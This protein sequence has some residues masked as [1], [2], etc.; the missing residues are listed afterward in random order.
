GAGAREVA[1]NGIDQLEPPA[2]GSL[3]LAHLVLEAVEGGLLTVASLGAKAL[4]RAD[5]P[6]GLRALLAAVGCTDVHDAAWNRFAFRAEAERLYRV[7]PGLPRIVPS[8]IPA[9]IVDATY[10]IDLGHASDAECP[11]AEFASL[12]QELSG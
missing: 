4:L 11:P 10:R 7:G 3:H 2:G 12:L 6:A 9:G 1:I 8:M 5:D